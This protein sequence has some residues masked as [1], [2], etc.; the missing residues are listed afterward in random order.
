[1]FLL[2]RDW[3]RD[4]LVIIPSMKK[5]ERCQLRECD[6]QLN[7][8]DNLMEGMGKDYRIS[9]F[10]APS[11][12]NIAEYCRVGGFPGTPGVGEGVSRRERRALGGDLPKEKFPRPVAAGTRRRLW[13]QG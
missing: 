7:L 13:L 6:N 1:M 5:Q 8:F 10:G 4:G 9:S 12:E 2:R 3:A 11:R